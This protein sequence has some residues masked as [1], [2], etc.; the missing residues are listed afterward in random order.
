[1]K[2]TPSYLK[3]VVNNGKLIDQAFELA[4]EQM[5]LIKQK[6]TVQANITLLNIKNEELGISITKLENQID[7]LERSVNGTAKGETKRR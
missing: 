2:K 4:K 7:K 5:E 6:Q 3:L 1:M